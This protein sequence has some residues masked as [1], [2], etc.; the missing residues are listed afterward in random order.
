MKRKHLK[1]Q[2]ELGDQS[3]TKCY[4][5]VRFDVEIYVTY[6]FKEFAV[7]ILTP[8]FCHISKSQHTDL[9]YTFINKYSFTIFPNILKSLLCQFI[10]PGNINLYF[11]I[12]KVLQDYMY[13]N[14]TFFST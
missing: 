11:P 5:L 10:F 13:Q 8:K 9:K 3:S 4:W 14:L 1:S 6:F 12:V 2:N 7:K